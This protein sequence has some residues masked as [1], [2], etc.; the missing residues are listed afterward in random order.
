MRMTP[1]ERDTL[2]AP[3]PV[4]AVP[5][6]T[7]AGR[8]RTASPPAG[9]ELVPEVE[10]AEILVARLPQP[11]VDAGPVTAELAPS[12]PPPLV[13]VTEEARGARINSLLAIAALLGVITVFVGV[14]IASTA[15]SGSSGSAKPAV[16]PAAPQGTPAEH[17]RAAA[18]AQAKRDRG[19]DAQWQ[20]TIPAATSA[21]P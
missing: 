20:D 9:A 14:L 4:N 1:T 8:R 12:A 11:A 19:T 17:A 5:P 15:D 16:R 2:T 13:F 3:A 18:I 10:S 21:G 7:A 6:A